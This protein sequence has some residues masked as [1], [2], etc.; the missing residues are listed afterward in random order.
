MK[1][2]IGFAL[3]L[4]LIAGSLAAPAM[5]KKKKKPRKPVVTQVDQK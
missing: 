3:I 2:I 5:A 1:R 4:G